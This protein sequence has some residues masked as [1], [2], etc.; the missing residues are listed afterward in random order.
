MHVLS[1]WSFIVDPVFKVTWKTTLFYIVKKLYTIRKGLLFFIKSVMTLKDVI[2]NIG[3]SLLG[4]LVYRS[5]TYTSF[6]KKHKEISTLLSSVAFFCTSQESSCKLIASYLAACYL[7]EVTKKWDRLKAAKNVDR[8]ANALKSAVKYRPSPWLLTA[9]VSFAGFSCGYVYYRFPNFSPKW[10]QTN[11]AILAGHNKLSK[12]RLEK[13]VSDY[14]Q[15]CSGHHHAMESCTLSNLSGLFENYVKCF[16]MGLNLQVPSL[17][18]KRNVKKSLQIAHELSYFA[19]CQLF[20]VGSFV[21]LGNKFV[22]KKGTAKRV[23]RHFHTIIIGS[24]STYITSRYLVRNT[25]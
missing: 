24:L 5:T 1:F 11:V 25:Y 12:D 17:I 6:G 4:T 20:L 23:Y 7:L 21:C 3:P 14:M 10:F 16:V 13:Y 9:H 18:L 15:H 2:T 19:A 22:V 8:N